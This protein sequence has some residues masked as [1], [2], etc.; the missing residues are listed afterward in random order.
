MSHHA[1]I[2]RARNTTAGALLCTAV[3]LLWTLTASAAETSLFPSLGKAPPGFEDLSE[4]QTTQAD[5]YYN[6]ELLLSTFVEYDIEQVEILNPEVVV[7]AVPALLNPEAITERLSGPRS[8]NSAHLCHRRADAACGSLTPAVVDVLFDADR[9]RLDLFIHPDQLRV[10]QIPR[11]RYLPKPEA[12]LALLHDLSINAAGQ[13]GNDRFS[14]VSESFLS[15]G[16]SRLQSRYGLSNEGLTLYELSVQWDEPDRESELGSFRT[17]GSSSSFINDVNILGVRIASSTNTRTD[18]DSALG[19]PLLVFL[20]RRSR[21]DLLRDGELLDSRFYAAGNQQLDTTRLPDGAYQLTIRI[22]DG[23]GRERTETAFFVR[24]GAIPPLGESRFYL[25]AG[26]LHDPDHRSRRAFGAGAPEGEW[27]R[28]GGSHRIS[29]ALAMEAELLHASSADYLTAGAFWFLPGWQ[30]RLGLLS[31]NAGDRGYSLRGN[32][33]LGAVHWSFDYQRVDA[34]DAASLNSNRIINGDYEQGSTTLA[35]PLRRG[36]GFVRA[37]YNQRELLP[38]EKG[39]GLS[40]LGPLVTKRRWAADLTF[41]SNFGPDSTWVRFG[42]NF[43]WRRDGHYLSATPQYQFTNNGSQ[44]RSSAS[45][46]DAR[47]SHSSYSE[48]FGDVQR[49][50]YALR[51]DDRTIVGSRLTSQSRRGYA[52]LDVAHEDGATRS[53]MSYSAN[54][55]FSMVTQ[56]GRTALG[57]GNSQLAAVIVDIEGYELD[58]EF[59]ILIDDRVAG[60]VR[61]GKRSVVTLR[62]YET[63]GVRVQ[64]VGDKLYNYDETPRSVTLY[65]GNVQTLSFTAHEITVLVGQAVLPSGKPVV[66]GRIDTTEGV[67]ATDA[68][69]WFQVEV[70]DFAPLQVR[71][72][73]EHYCAMILPK[74]AAV[75]GLAVVGAVTCNPTRGPRSD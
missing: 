10:L 65:P 71:Y 46:V 16:E 45:F 39:V 75:D 64:P 34:G 74:V 29:E 55:R 73:P 17:S 35:F 9:F 22:L 50:L 37:R 33:E 72:G 47:W 42:I 31:S 58:T 56:Q 67:G 11:Q 28:V 13:D 62:P 3:A 61:S 51:D 25:E 23:D 8:S 57:G 63:Y 24:S 59:Q 41:D 69:G 53:G 70:R 48:R 1:T 2:A 26:A 27:A 68:Q 60:H 32:L 5:V 54:G 19:S 4:Q 12:G 30:M 14:I 40:Y 7:R 38:A 66:G 43:R 52:D 18:L 36:Q 6:G 20:D 44:D 49:G 15:K 21:V